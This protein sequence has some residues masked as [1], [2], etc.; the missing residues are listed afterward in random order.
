MIHIR[1]S[2]R[3]IQWHNVYNCTYGIGNA[4]LYSHE[5]RKEETQQCYQCGNK[6]DSRKELMGHRNNQ[7]NDKFSFDEIQK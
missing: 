7:W 6:F 5:K 2:H 4:C 3:N 1:H